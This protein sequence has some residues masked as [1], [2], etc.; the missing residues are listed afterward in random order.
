MALAT[1]LLNKAAKTNLIPRNERLTR[2]PLTM[3][4]TKSMKELKRERPETPA[5]VSAQLI[6]NRFIFRACMSV[7][8]RTVSLGDFGKA[9][10]ASLAYRLYR[11]WQRR[12]FEN[13]PQKPETRTYNKR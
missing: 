6:G 13:I 4:P 10:R 7:K 8:G 11:L 5:G 2:Q 12:G 1:D 9:E 3:P